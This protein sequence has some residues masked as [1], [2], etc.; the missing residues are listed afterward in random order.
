MNKK[1]ML[2]LDTAL[3]SVILTVDHI[4]IEFLSR[5]LFDAT[6]IKKSSCGTYAP[7]FLLSF[8]ECNYVLLRK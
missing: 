1:P 6:M 4:Y 2:I 7:G 8:G 3:L 5:N